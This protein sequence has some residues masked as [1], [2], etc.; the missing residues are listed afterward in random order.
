MVPNFLGHPVYRKRIKPDG[1]PADVDGVGTVVLPDAGSTVHT[2]AID[3]TTSFCLSPSSTINISTRSY[4]VWSFYYTR[5][6]E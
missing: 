1:W 3:K 2:R 5:F 4:I 6:F